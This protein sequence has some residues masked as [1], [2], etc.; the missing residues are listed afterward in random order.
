MRLRDL[1][2]ALVSTFVAANA[3]GQTDAAPPPPAPPLAPMPPPQQPAVSATVMP[4]LPQ[5]TVTTPGVMAP[6]PVDPPW[7]STAPP[8]GAAPAF[9]GPDGYPLAG[10]IGEYFY[11]RDAH[12]DFRIYF[13]G[14]VHVDGYFPFGPGVSDSAAGS[15]LEPTFFIRRARPELGGE[16]LGHWQ[17]M[18]A[19]D[20][21]RTAVSDPNGQTDTENC[22]VNAKTSALACAL[23]SSPV[24]APSYTA[25]PTDVF[26][27]YRLAKIF[28]VEAGQFKIPFGLE[29]RTSE[30]ITP[31]LENSLPVRTIGAPLNRDIGVMAW[32]E[33]ESNLVHYEVGIFNGG[34]PN[35]TNVDSNFDGIGRVFARP[36]AMT[37]S[38]A[39]KPLQIGVSGH[40]GVR[41]A[42]TVGYD[43]P[44]FTTQ[45][46]YSFWKPTYTDSAGSLVHIIP[47]SNQITVGGEFYWPVS[48]VDLTSEFMYADHDTRE[49]LDG[50]QTAYPFTERYG[51]IKGFSYYAQISV[52]A[53]GDR[54]YVRRPGYLDPPHINFSA[55]LPPTKSSIE[56]LAKFEQLHM[57][58]EGASRAGTANSKTPD[59]SIDADVFS[60]GVNFWATRRVRVTLNYDLNFFPD[61]E[62]TTA[63]ATG[64]AAQTSTQRAVAP[65]QLLPVGTDNGTRESGHTLNELTARVAVGF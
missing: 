58:Y 20:W 59:G 37:A 48:I 18:V 21:G 54:Q 15:G 25:Q 27:N 46:G 63:S 55:P 47:S 17:W 60:L 41:S 57:D 16:F 34:G 2:L 4:A 39:L 13:S 65:A 61:S 9:A 64:A 52:W 29:N 22:T 19:G 40:Y 42:R 38:G 53:M 12:D 14:R 8:P 30:N 28:N 43:Y 23:R 36:F 7:P 5:D 26:I 3:W 6:P 51:S 32:G 50:Y 1:G 10:R 45:E 31:F 35:V 11:L 49:A 44:A 24:Q 62:P 33:T 56:L